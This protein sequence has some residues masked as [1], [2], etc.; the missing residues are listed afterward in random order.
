[1]LGGDILHTKLIQAALNQYA[2]YGYD[3]ATMRKIAEEVGIKPASI[4]YFYKNKEE[5][6][7]AAFQHLLDNHFCKMENILKGHKDKPIQEIFNAMLQGIVDHHTDD[8]Q[9]T[10]AYISL[11]TSP[12]DEISDYLHN[13][14][15]RY[16]DWLTESLESILKKRYPG[17]ATNEVDGLVK[18]FILIGNGVFW[19]IKLYEGEV[20]KEQMSLAEKIIQSL[21]EEINEKYIKQSFS[22]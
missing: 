5:L 19:G 11:V 8:M 3:G 16:N 1:M 13:H 21:C 22:E 2:I 10:N 4:Y 17:M 15:L 18:Q 20:L 14:M 7:I 6:F 12:L 9:G